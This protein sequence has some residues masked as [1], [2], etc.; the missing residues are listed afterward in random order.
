MRCTHVTVV[1]HN[2]LLEGTYVHCSSPS[3]W[4]GGNFRNKF[5][6][7][8]TGLLVHVSHLNALTLLTPSPPHFLT[9]PHPLTPSPP[10][11]SSPPHFLTL[12][13]SSH[14]F[15]PSPPH[16]PHPLTSSPSP[17]IPPPHPFTPSLSS[18]LTSS[19]TLTPSSHPLTHHLTPSSHPLT[20]SPPAPSPQMNT[21][22]HAQ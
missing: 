22:N 20:P 11:L 4:N 12:T 8:Y 15:T 18:P 13:P 6:L 2:I 9:P 19:I 3:V 17:L 5:Y 16:S 10:S 1:C 14:P 21:R 7:R